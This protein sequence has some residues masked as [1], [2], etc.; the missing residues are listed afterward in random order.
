MDLA[1]WV[2]DGIAVAALIV[3]VMF[4]RQSRV[5]KRAAAEAKRET[6]SMAGSL[7]KIAVSLSARMN[8]AGPREAIGGS[9]TALAVPAFTLEAAGGA[10]YRLRNA[11]AAPATGVRFQ[12]PQGHQVSGYEQVITTDL[13]PA[14]S[15]GFYMTPEGDFSTSPLGELEVSCNELDSPVYV[16]VP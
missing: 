2:G 9:S 7:E 1:S 5:A 15:I 13:G 4:G 14:Q 12:V 11:S 10:S 16:P 6:A 3:S 8:P